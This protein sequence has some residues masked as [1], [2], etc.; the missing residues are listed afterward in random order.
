MHVH[1]RVDACAWPPRESEFV[2][3]GLRLCRDVGTRPV[4]PA[5]RIARFP[6]LSEVILAEVRLHPRYRPSDRDVEE[7]LTESG[8]DAT[9]CTCH[10][11][12]VDLIDNLISLNVPSF[13]LPRPAA[14][15][16]QRGLPTPGGATHQLRPAGQSSAQR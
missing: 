11:M 4:F 2:V 8:I 13:Q 10:A 14:T 9:T 5:M 3:P 7:L 16:A 15:R 12:F 1:M 6:V